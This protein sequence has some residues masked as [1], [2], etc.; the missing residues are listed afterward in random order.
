PE[1]PLTARVAVNR[2]WQQLF[3]TG[4]VKTSFDFGT[5]GEPPTHPELLD[6][7]ATTFR[8][9]G[10]GGRGLGRVMGTS[11]TFRQ[12]S[13]G[14]PELERQDPANRIYARGPRFRLDAEPIRD[15]ALFVSGLLN[16]H[17]GGKG[18]RPY[19]PPNI[20]EPVAYT[21]SNTRSYQQDSGS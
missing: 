3:G 21:G 13:R 12:S 7:L 4:L 1:H 2:I 11:A 9:R 19:Q 6:W 20:W 8:D 10:W 17:M 18:V 14:T 15:N 5:Q 16:L